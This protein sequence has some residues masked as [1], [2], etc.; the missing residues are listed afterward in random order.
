MT[1]VG[2]YSNTYSDTYAAGG[3]GGGTVPPRYNPNTPYVAG[4]EWLGVHNIALPLSSGQ[5]QCAQFLSTVTETIQ[6]LTPMVHAN[7]AGSSGQR[8]QLGVDL[9]D[10]SAL[11][12]TGFVTA[13]NWALAVPSSNASTGGSGAG[14]GHGWQ[15]QAAGSNVYTTWT[16]YDST[17]FQRVNDVVAAN[18]PLTE[19]LADSIVY[20][21]ASASPASV[22]FNAGSTLYDGDTG[23]Q[24]Q[25]IAGK[26]IEWVE[27]VVVANNQ[28]ENGCTLDGVITDPNGLRFTSDS[29]PIALPAKSG[30]KRIRFGFLWNSSTHQSWDL[31]A[32]QRFLTGGRTFGVQAAAQPNG[33][34]T[35]GLIVTA[36]MIQFRVSTETRIATG[37]QSVPIGKAWNEITLVDPVTRENAPWAKVAGTTY[38]AAFHLTNDGG[39]AN[40]RALDSATVAGHETD[41]LTGMSSGT[42]PYNLGGA[43]PTALPTLGVPAMSLMLGR[44]DGAASQDS[45]P[46][47]AS[48]TYPVNHVNAAAQFISNEEAGVYGAASVLLQSDPDG[49]GGVLQDAPLEVSL[50]ARVGGGL[51]AGPASIAPADV[52]PDGKLH[53]IQV[54]FPAA[55]TLTAGQ[56]VS[57]VLTSSSVAPWQ[58]VAMRTGDTTQ[59][60]PDPLGLIAAAVGIGSTDDFAVINGFGAFPIDLP[61]SIREVPPIL[62]GLASSATTMANQPTLLGAYRAATLGLASLSWTPSTLA[63]QFAYYE[64]QRLDY[65]TQEASAGTWQ[66]IAHVTVEGAAYFNDLE[67][68]ANTAVGYRVRVV[69]DPLGASDWATFNSVTVPQGANDF[70]FASNWDSELSFSAQDADVSNAPDRGYDKLPGSGGLTVKDLYG[71]DYPAAF[72][73]SERGSDVFTRRLLVATN[74]EAVLDG[75]I[76]GER[77]LFDSLVAIFHSPNLPYVMV[78]DGLG[79]RWFA[80]ADITHATTG[81]GMTSMADVTFVEIAFRPDPVV[82]PT[83]WIP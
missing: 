27:I 42:V 51:L 4:S 39:S 2:V 40:L 81:D 17:A 52:D 33:F 16:P 53:L 56:A 5:G 75:N 31:L 29:G 65:L 41:A 62:T 73:Q 49:H 35:H 20:S 24:N 9:Y 21:P 50:R 64:V 74:D 36:V 19:G 79:R 70:V 3:T 82:A 77:A 43:V 71:A 23:L 38:L 15:L 55:V 44:A 10:V 26:R 78:R 45:Q 54:R 58:T 30:R 14:I 48:L 8:V 72:R 83:P 47:A 18:D 22:M 61:V 37:Y 69:G 28:L 7:Q 6:T 59:P 11:G 34:S 66:T 12:P 80:A 1:L 63:A 60:L 32:A 68:P 67:L 13:R 25:T 46:Y 76:P 57:V